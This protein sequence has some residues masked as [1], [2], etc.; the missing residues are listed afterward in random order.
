LT[1]VLDVYLNLINRESLTQNSVR[2][3]TDSNKRLISEFQLCENNNITNNKG[4]RTKTHDEFV[5]EIMNSQPSVEVVGKY[6]NRRTKIRCRCKTCGFEWE[7]IPHT[8]ING[9]GCLKCSKHN[10]KTTEDFINELNQV[11]KTIEILEEYKGANTHI[12][13]RCKKC[14][15]EWSPRA[16]TLLHGSSCPK[17][18]KMKKTHDE[19]VKEMAIILPTIDIIGNYCGCETPIECCCKVCGNKWNS[20]PHRMLKGDGCQKCGYI[21]SAEIQRKPHEQFV[22]ELAIIN[23]NVFVVGKYLNSKSKIECQCVDCGQ[24]WPAL[25]S[26]LLSG[27]GCPVCARTQ[28]SF[29]EKLILLMLQHVLGKDAVLPRDR[30][31]I[32][33]EIDIYIPSL[34]AG[35]EFGSWYWHKTRVNRDMEKYDCC[36]EKAIHLI[37]IYDRFDGD[38][39]KLGFDDTF[40]TYSCNLG[41]I[42][43]RAELK[44]CVVN[45]FNLLNLNYSFT[46]DEERELFFNAKMMSARK[47][48]ED[49][50]RELA[51]INPNIELMGHYE[52]ALTKIPCRCKVCGNK[53][54]A[55]AHKLINQKSGCPMCNRRHKKVINIDTGE[56]FESL[57]EAGRKLGVTHHAIRYAC[58]NGGTC[59]GGHFAYL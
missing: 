44:G 49:I 40:I 42:N 12:Q 56:I 54:E 26:N 47:T 11:N 3:H 14:G 46:E 5:V 31:A 33:K 52:D 24:K 15:N 55:S 17:C 19:F 51:K 45:I 13:C 21:K 43:K 16:N 39:I 8:I 32:G 37:T 41:D 6:V 25:P 22:A 18:S 38:R 28:T 1:T 4:R 35:V 20:V 53:W 23:P 59:K 9:K 29:V 57:S 36:R 7:S 2:S 48:T 27:H 50:V 10:R 34:Q 58:L 30:S